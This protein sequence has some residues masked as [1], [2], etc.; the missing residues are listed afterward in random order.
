MG[1][2]DVYLTAMIGAF[3][4][5]PF[6]LVTIFCAALTG[7]IMGILYIVSTKQGR[8]SPIP[9]GPFLSIGGAVV[10]LFHNQVV[11]MFALLGVFL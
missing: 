7:S 8:E 1:L 4:G 10:I 5:F 2:G 11:E 3:V 6:I 9:F